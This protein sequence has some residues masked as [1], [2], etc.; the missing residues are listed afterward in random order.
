MGSDSQA[1]PTRWVPGAAATQRLIGDTSDATLPL[2]LGGLLRQEE[3]H[4][5][6]ER[7]V[8]FGMGLGRMQ[9]TPTATKTKMNGCNSIEFGRPKNGDAPPRILL[10]AGVRRPGVANELRLH[11]LS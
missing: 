5:E 11:R 2:V 9:R 6:G 4:R 8:G 1:P 10:R 3:M 7:R